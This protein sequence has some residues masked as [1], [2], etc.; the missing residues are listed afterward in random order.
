MKDNI[1]IS[2]IIPV[3][4]T[5]KYLD[6]CLNSILLQTLEEIEI[7]VVNDNSTDNSLNIIKEYIKKDNRI[8]LIDKK[9][10]EGVSQARNS[11]IE[12]AQGKYIFCIDSDDWI[13]EKCLEEMYERAISYNADVVITDF[14]FDL[15][16]KNR[17]YYAV[18]QESEN[19]VMSKQEIFKNILEQKKTLPAIWNKLIKKELYIKNNIKFPVGISVGEDL[20]VTTILLYFSEKI[21]KLNKAYLHYVQR[22][23]SITKQ[24]K[25][26]ILTDIYFVLKEIEKFFYNNNFNIK[27]DYLIL[28]HLSIWIF[29]I[30][31][32]YDN[33]E[34]IEV[35][36]TYT[37]LLEKNKNYTNG[38]NY[39]KYYRFFRKI[40]DPKISFKMTWKITNYKKK[41]RKIIDI[42]KGD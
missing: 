25:F 29:N 15:A 5:E 26:S 38:M 6:Q 27:L 16:E 33:K 35:L 21:V 17:V 37:S 20:L 18:D 32:K 14:Y 24:Y 40:F 30:K 41:I 4:N 19:I 22:E 13:E 31:P 3:Y 28:N 42:V 7:I 2:V 34:Y 10:N 36:N 8:I 9:K 11:G 39:I 1:K 12:A 23:N